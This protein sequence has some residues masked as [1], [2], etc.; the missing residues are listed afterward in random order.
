MRNG[1]V[2]ITI[3]D[4]VGLADHE[5][6]FGPIHPVDEFIRMSPETKFPDLLHQLGFFSSKSQAGWNKEIPDGWSNW[7]EKASYLYPQNSP[8]IENIC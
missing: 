7:E 6:F 5:L 1:E 3:G 8:V 4:G 2:N